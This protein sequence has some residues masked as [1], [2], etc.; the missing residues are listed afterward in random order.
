M[1]SRA[2]TSHRD[3]TFAKELLVANRVVHPSLT[4]V[5]IPYAHNYHTE[6]SV[7]GNNRTTTFNSYLSLP[8]SILAQLN[9]LDGAMIKAR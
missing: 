8:K 7:L 5:S 6:Y 9:L 3:M 1:V 4:A 2:I